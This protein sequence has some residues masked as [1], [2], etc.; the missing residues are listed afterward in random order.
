MEPTGG[1]WIKCLSV[2]QVDTGGGGANGII[3]MAGGGI[4][5]VVVW[6]WYLVWRSYGDIWWYMGGALV[7][8]V[9]LD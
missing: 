3:P 9:L 7:V 1:Q 4:C 5:M 8:L 2:D 6:R